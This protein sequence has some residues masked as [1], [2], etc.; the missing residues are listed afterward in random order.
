M[1][2]KAVGWRKA[3]PVVNL[4]IAVPPEI[5]ALGDQGAAGSLEPDVA[6]TDVAPADVD[7]VVSSVDGV[8]VTIG[9]SEAGSGGAAG[10]GAVVT[11]VGAAALDWVGAAV[12]V[13]TVPS[14]DTVTVEPRLTPAD[15]ATPIMN[16]ADPSSAAAISTMIAPRRTVRR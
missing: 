16:P 13:P 9:C 10:A 7:G 1:A 4:G 8:V 12:H 2:G 3:V 6:S 15:A 11:V 5:S 14:I